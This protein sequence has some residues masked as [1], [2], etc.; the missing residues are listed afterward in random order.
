MPDIIFTSTLSYKARQK[1]RG[2]LKKLHFQQYPTEPS[3]R[4]RGGQAL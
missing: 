4:S 3:D 2:V 1:L